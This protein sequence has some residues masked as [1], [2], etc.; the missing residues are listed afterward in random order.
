ME[1]FAGVCEQGLKVAETSSA[2]ISLA[3][4]QSHDPI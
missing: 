3:R 4:I 1:N 2:H